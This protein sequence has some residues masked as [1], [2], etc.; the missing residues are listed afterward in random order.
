M[1]KSF[2]N[3]HF[4]AAFAAL[5][6]L[7]SA[8]RLEGQQPPASAVAWSS[9]PENPG[10]GGRS[11]GPGAA[12]IGVGGAWQPGPAPP[13]AEPARAD[14]GTQAAGPEPVTVRSL[15]KDLTKNLW[16]DG[17][18]LVSSPARVRPSDLRWL[19]PLAAASAGAF[20]ADTHTMRA[21]VSH[22]PDFNDANKTMSDG[23]RAALAGAPVAMLAAGLLE[24]DPHLGEAGTLGTEA[25]IEAFVLDEGIKI[26]TFR[27]RPDSHHGRGNFFEGDAGLDSSFVSGHAITSWASAAVLAGEYPSRWVRLGVYGAAATVSVNR[28]LAQQH[29]PSDVLVGSAVGWLIGNYVFR[30]HHRPAPGLAPE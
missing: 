24:R 19:L 27:E 7:L 5:V 15:P 22:D 1:R 6:M 28:V 3:R 14:A 8:L 29:F 20:A 25:V 9:L 23:L 26:C 2:P 10:A 13:A 18:G 17:L 4:A 11:S 16:I 21:V 12:T 30:R